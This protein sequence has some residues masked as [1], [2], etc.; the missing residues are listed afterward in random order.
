MLDVSTILVLL[1]LGLASLLSSMALFRHQRVTTLLAAAIALFEAQWLLLTWFDRVL[2]VGVDSE[3]VY[4]AGAVILLAMWASLYK[5]WRLAWRD[6]ASSGV[7][8]IVVLAVM[9]V[10]LAGTALVWTANGFQEDGTWISHG[11]FNGDTATFASLV[12][13]SFATDSLVTQNPFAGNGYLEYP[14]LLHGAFASFFAQLGIGTTWLN[15]LPLLTYVFIFAT[16]PLFFLPWDMVFP[17]PRE[18]H[19]KWFGIPS[20]FLIFL[21]QGVVVLYVLAL[22]WDSFVYPQSHFFLMGLFMLL[23][24]SFAQSF[25]QGIK[26][27][28]PAIVLTILLMLSNAVTGTAAVAAL[29][30]Y[31]ALKMLTKSTPVL[32]RGLHGVLA[33]LLVGLF[34]LHSAG[35]PVFGLVPHFSYTA[36]V[37][38]VRYAPL[39]AL[40]LVGLW[41]AIP[42]SLFLSANSSVLLVLAVFT[43]FFSQRDIVVENASRFFYHAL[44]VG[45]PFLLHPAI[46]LYYA[47]R[48]EVRYSTHSLAE[49][50][51]YTALLLVAVFLL[52]LPAVSSVASAHDNLMFKD[53]QTIDLSTR[54]ALWWIEENTSPDGVFLASPEPPWAIPFMTGR[55][56]LRADYWLSPDDIVLSDVRAAFAGDKAAQELVISQGSAQYLFLTQSD[57]AAWEPLAQTKVFDNTEIAIFKLR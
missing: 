18:A 17:E 8:D 25:Q 12:Q 5:K 46:Q 57:R 45:F 26:W 44:L 39:V 28:V 22:S 55:S 13:R 2:V 23:I 20:R 1:V 53:E 14:T 38:M 30:V 16:I 3:T 49:L 43:F 29:G 42:R 10:V 32:Q 7:R 31:F 54:E 36:A 41:Q 34:L 40:L 19:V 50:F 51:S 4:L 52:A 27:I 33:V 11:F 9:A 15:F 48:R 47:L 6:L 56:I 21:G 35:D 37:E 24:A